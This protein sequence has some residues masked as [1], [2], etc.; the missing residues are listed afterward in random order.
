MTKPNALPPLL[1]ENDAL[2]LSVRYWLDES[3]KEAADRDQWK[4]KA[5]ATE[6]INASLHKEIA[7]LQAENAAL[8]K[9]ASRFLLKPIVE[10]AI[11]PAAS[12]DSGS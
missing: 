12:N 5:E 11:K 8:H 9:L 10:E 6:C 3:L 4:A 2:K 1:D 7:K